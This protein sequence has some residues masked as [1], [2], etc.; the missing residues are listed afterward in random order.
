[1]FRAILRAVKAQINWWHNRK[2]FGEQR[3]RQELRAT[4]VAVAMTTTGALRRQA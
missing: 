1:M 3:R 4:S 2:A